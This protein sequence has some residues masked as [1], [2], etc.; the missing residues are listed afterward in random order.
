MQ[1]FKDIQI[2][3]AYLR[4]LKLMGTSINTSAD[5][6]PV[7]DTD[8]SCCSSSDNE[9]L[10]SLSSRRLSL[11]TLLPE[12]NGS[13][14][15]DSKSHRS[16]SAR[17][18]DYNRAMHSSTPIA[19]PKRKVVRVNNGTQT[20]PQ[21]DLDVVE[22]RLRDLY[23]LFLSVLIRLE[24]KSAA[25]TTNMNNETMKKLIERIPS[26]A[27][28]RNVKNMSLDEI[29]HELSSASSEKEILAFRLHKDL[30]VPPA[31]KK[32]TPEPPQSEMNDIISKNLE[33]RR[34]SPETS[35]DNNE[36]SSPVDE[37]IAIGDGYAKIPARILEEINWS[38]YTIATRQLLRASFSRKVLATHSLS[39]KQSPA[40]TN[41]PAKKRLDPNL[42]ND[43]VNTVSTKCGIDKQC[44]RNVITVKCTDEA[45]LY[46]MRQQ[47]RTRNNNES[48]SPGSDNTSD[49]N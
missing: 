7:T 47:Q 9:F 43:I 26:G 19:I 42:V 36:S 20:N 14:S 28:A 3:S 18:S 29:L 5:A 41:K 2:E 30:P 33:M 45:K 25:E 21:E 48:V 13:F 17:Y 27:I 4:G 38:S 22:N 35:N 11:P 32:I 39:G 8:S 40:F 49:S 6:N 1:S 44:V 24:I 31:E 34:I 23:S 10:A 46:R 12:R 15:S 37:M 16:L